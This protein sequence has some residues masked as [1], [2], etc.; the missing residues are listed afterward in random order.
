MPLLASHPCYATDKSF[1]VS[2]HILQHTQLLI[3]LANS[4]NPLGILYIKSIFP[5]PKFRKLTLSVIYLGRK[6]IAKC[7]NVPIMHLS[8]TIFLTFVHYTDEV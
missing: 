6:M 3:I 2:G 5:K 8:T 4:V 7:D 1:Q